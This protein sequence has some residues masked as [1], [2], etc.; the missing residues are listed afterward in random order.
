[1]LGRTFQWDT[2]PPAEYRITDSSV[3]GAP[4]NGVRFLLYQVDTATGKPSL[5]LQTTGYLDLTDASTAQANVLQLLLKVGSQTAANYTITEVKT[6]TSL[7]LTAAGYVA[8]VVSGG[9]TVH[10]T[11]SHML[12]L[13]D[14]SL[15]TNYQAS[16][17]SATV[18]LVSSISGSGGTPTLTMDWTVTKGGSVEIVG[19]STDSAINVQFKVNGATIATVVGTPL[20][21]TVTPPTAPV[22]ALGTMLDGF[23]AI[24]YNLSLVFVPSF[25]VFG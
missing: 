15:S 24:Y 2:T 10:F 11:L 9:A 23:L 22:A 17:G 21:L 20:S 8:N 12:A 6:T 16:D 14:S 25:L 4:A 3:T 13:A 18:S 7:S 1:M 19:T 5:P